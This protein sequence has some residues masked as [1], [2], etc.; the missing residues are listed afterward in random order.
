MSRFARPFAGG[1]A[2]THRKPFGSCKAR[3]KP[4]RSKNFLHK[5]KTASNAYFIAVEVG[6]KKRGALEDTGRK[7][8][9]GGGRR[10][11]G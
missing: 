5:N 6:S 11:A 8:S 9:V 4:K 1:M 7:L 10:A 2:D 3:L